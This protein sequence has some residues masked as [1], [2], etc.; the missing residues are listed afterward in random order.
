MGE[1]RG[2]ADQAAEALLTAIQD[3]A[4]TARRRLS[5]SSTRL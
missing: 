5:V 1:L 3:Q 4:R 2:L